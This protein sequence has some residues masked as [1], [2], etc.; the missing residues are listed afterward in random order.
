MSKPMAATMPTRSAGNVSAPVSYRG[1]AYLS[2]AIGLIT[3]GLTWLG[4]THAL[5][6]TADNPDLSQWLYRIAIAGTCLSALLLI[7]PV[8]ALMHLRQ[9][10]SLVGGG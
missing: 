3:I 1:I 7:F 9:A 10:D 6:F 8:R 5:S 2:A 4:L